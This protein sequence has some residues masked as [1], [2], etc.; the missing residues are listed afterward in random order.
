MSDAAFD[1]VVIN[2]RERPLS[3]DINQLQ[4]EISR[5]LREV[6]RAM[7]LPHNSNPQIVNSSFNPVSGFMGDGFF[8]AAG[9]ALTHTIKA[10]LGLVFDSGSTDSDIGS[11]SKVDDRS[12]YYPVYLSADQTISS[13]AAPGVGLERVDIIE[14]ALDRRL[15]DTA[16]RDVLDTGTGVFNPSSVFKTLA[17]SLDGRTGVV[18]S[19]ANSS[20]G[21]GLKAGSTQVAGTYA[22]SGGVTGVPTTSPGYTRVA[23]ILVTN[24]GL[25]VQGDVR[26]TRFLLSP[27]GVQQWGFELL[28]VPGTPNDTFTISNFPTSP[29]GYR[30]AAHQVSAPS[31]GGP[32]R[33]YVF[34]GRIATNSG[35]LVRAD[36][37]AST[38]ANANRV[39][40]SS[41]V[42]T[43]AVTSAIKSALVAAGSTNFEAAIGQEYMMWEMDA[44]R[45]IDLGDPSDTNRVFHVMGMNNPR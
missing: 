38:V 19:P 4:S 9:G 30:F 12:P 14:V 15:A 18:T 21:I 42:T 41:V 16:S 44:T 17:Y 35:A 5:T 24:T 36:C 28:Q 20:T 29:A 10:G 31:N 1:R 43:G 37:K 8:V 40:R 13:P 11:V 3:S 25:V 22:A 6:V 45:L 34:G 26:D 23:V 32:V 2:P 7:C 33:C 27:N 39:V